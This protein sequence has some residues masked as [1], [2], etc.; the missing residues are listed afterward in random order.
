ML[1]KDIEKIEKMLSTFKGSY[2]DICFQIYPI[3]LNCDNPAGLLQYFYENYEDIESSEEDE[4]AIV[5]SQQEKSDLRNQYG[6]LVDGVLDKLIKKN[7]EAS[8]FYQELWNNINCD[9]LFET[10][11]E[12][13]FA[14]SY[15]LRDPRI[16]Y[17][18][19]TEGMKM[20]NEIFREYFFSLKKFLKKARFIITNEYEQQTERASLLLELFDEV[21]D[22]EK[23]VILMSYIIAFL[24]ENEFTTSE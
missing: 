8:I 22:K 24:G 7:L 17:F 2:M 6:G 12:K 10:Q 9:L 4:I 20:S 19:M 18:E 21:Q 16:P 14:M 15:I 13:V 1:Q 5:F 3:I 23:K 11:K